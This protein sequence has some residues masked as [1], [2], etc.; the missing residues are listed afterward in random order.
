MPPSKALLKACGNKTGSC[1]EIATGQGS[2]ACK[3]RHRHEQF[4]AFLRQV[5]RAHPER[6]LHL[7]MDNYAA[8]KH[9]KIKAWLAGNPRVSVHFTPTHA[10]WMNLVEVWF[11]WCGPPRAARSQDRR[12]RL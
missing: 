11:S 9:P 3:P 1:L 12:S 10:S 2:A 4:L 5:A 6:E 7:V 8:D